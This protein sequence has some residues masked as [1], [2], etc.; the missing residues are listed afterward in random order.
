MC[1]IT[2]YNAGVCLEHQALNEFRHTD[3]FGL[4]RQNIP[5]N[6]ALGR[7]KIHRGRT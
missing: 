7:K 4:R 1:D 5:Q 6:L 3:D 2:E